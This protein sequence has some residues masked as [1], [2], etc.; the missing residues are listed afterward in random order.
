MADAA[1]VGEERGEEGG[2]EREGE[3]GRE[4]SRGGAELQGRLCCMGGGVWL[5]LG[6]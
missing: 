1:A 4:E 6:G 2:G 5:G 3:R